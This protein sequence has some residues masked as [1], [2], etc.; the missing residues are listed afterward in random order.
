MINDIRGLVPKEHGQHG[1][2]SVQLS[3]LTGTADAEKNGATVPAKR[4]IA[5]AGIF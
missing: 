4:T 1:A 3:Q 5:I 2:E